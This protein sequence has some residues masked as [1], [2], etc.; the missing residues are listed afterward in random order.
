MQLPLTQ[1]QQP[2]IWQYLHLILK[3]E[4]Y[5]SKQFNFCFF[6]K[7]SMFNNLKPILVDCD[8]NL[9]VLILRMQKKN[10]ETLAIMVVHYGGYP[11]EV[12]K[13]TNFKKNKIK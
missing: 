11:A 5:F 8:P 6:C 4:K 2:Y 10:K 7:W 3:K 1:V 12:D 9:L 13:I